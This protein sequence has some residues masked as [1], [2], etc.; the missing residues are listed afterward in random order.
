M[1]DRELDRALHQSPP[2]DPAVLRRI[3]GGI[4][5]D[6]EP[7]QPLSPRLLAAQLIVV[8]AVVAFAGA[9]LLGFFG[10]RRLTTAQSAAIFTTVAVFLCFT[11]VISTAAIIPGARQR[12][13]PATLIALACAVLVGIFARAFPDYS[14]ASFVH[15]GIRCLTAGVLN[16]IPAALLAWLVLRRGFAVNPTAAGA[17]AGALAGLAGVLMLELHCPI[18]KAPHAMVWHVAVIPVCAA[19]GGLLPRIAPARSSRPPE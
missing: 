16:A 2:V 14:T 17:A 9:A 11:A 6:L 8:A 4:V 18:L 12:L 13:R 19:V 5:P 7:V 1:N 3:A 10:V 15:E